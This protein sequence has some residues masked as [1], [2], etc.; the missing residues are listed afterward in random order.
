M[1][2]IKPF[3]I[4]K[5]SAGSGKTYQLASLYIELGLR[6]PPQFNR[7][8]GVTF[9]NKATAEMK[10]RIIKLLRSLNRGD[11]KVLLKNLSSE[12]GLS[13]NEIKI[14]S[15]ELLSR[16]LHSYS[17]FSITTIDS[18]F[19]KVIRSFAREL[20]VQGSFTVELDL[21][22]VTT[23]VIDNLLGDVHDPA[24]KEIKNWLIRYAD[25]KIRNG[26]SWDVRKELT[27]LAKETLK[28]SFKEHSEKLLSVSK[29]KDYFK[30]IVDELIKIKSI[31]ENDL[32][33][34][35]AK[36]IAIVESSGG[37]GIFKYGKSGPANA[38]Y[39]IQ[40]GKYELGKRALNSLEGIDHWLNK[41]NQSNPEVAKKV[42]EILIPTLSEIVDYIQSNSRK[43]N[44][45]NE[46]LKYF[47]TYGLI[48]SMLEYFRL[49]RE[50]EEVMFISDLPD[51]LK[52]IINDSDTPYIFEK[53]GSRYQNYL[54]DE[55][56]D[57]SHF[58]WNNIKP[59]VK[60]AT[61]SGYKSLV[62][63]D[64][65][66][67]IYRWRGGDFDLLENVIIDDI[68]SYNTEV[69][70]LDKNW[71]SSPVIVNFNNNLVKEISNNFQG[72]IELP[73][74][75]QPLVESALSV[76][77]NAEQIPVKSD[78]K[79][80]VQIKYFVSEEESWKNKSL[81]DT[82]KRIEDLQ[83]RNFRL[84][85]I[86]ILVRKNDHAELFA[87]FMLAYKESENARKDC[88]YDV[89][90]SEA[91]KLSS[92]LPIRIVINVLKWLESG[93]EEFYLFQWLN[94]YQLHRKKKG[95]VIQTI[96]ALKNWK[97]IVPKKFLESLSG[98]E[99][100][101]L[102]DLISQLILTLELNQKTDDFVYLQGFQDAL[103][104]FIN[105]NN[106]DISSFLQWW[107]QRGKNRPVQLSEETNA[108]RVFTIHKAKGLE[109]PVV[110]IPFLDW[111]LDYSNN[112]N[113]N[114]LWCSPVDQSP[115]NKMPVIPLKYGSKLK[116]TYWSDHY[117]SEKTLNFLDAV[118]MLY[119]SFT[120]P[121]QVLI[122]HGE[123]SKTS[124]NV[125]IGNYLHSLI[126]QNEFWNEDTSELKIN[127]FP[128]SV[129][130]KIDFRDYKLK[131]YQIS[132]WRKKVSLKN[133]DKSRAM[134]SAAESRKR[135][136]KWHDYLS[137]I[138]KVAD[139]EKIKDIDFRKKIEELVST[140]DVKQFFND[141]DEVYTER[142][143]LLPNG[144][145]KRLDR[146]I[147]KGEKWQ[148]IDFKTGEEKKQDQSQIKEYQSVLKEM[149]IQPVQCFLIYV[150]SAKVMEV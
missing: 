105:S 65:K 27:K 113:E 18:F 87:D 36:G 58:Q 144:S 52:Q 83:H 1:S 130:E 55:F 17:Q 125:T 149:D 134:D 33:K 80:S 126:K 139:L 11:E 70:L 103:L 46:V 90:S 16:I 131:N 54:I 71:R 94:D 31:F 62:V 77:K 69:S 129:S 22:N 140:E 38:F 93:K 75:H 88:K 8:L 119:V 49:Y 74:E 150:E 97:S 37:P 35:S 64:A 63:G 143:I 3:S 121:T 108:I 25:L 28:D 24:N 147:K 79:G 32:K 82:V 66:Q 127:D 84:S 107:D 133:V 91:L 44:S 99:K 47:F 111:E 145:V 20:G 115:F 85:D 43:Y 5:A 23:M 96:N 110:I 112:L 21:D 137:K 15:S 4:V 86:C 29:E 148:L 7:I 61:D 48:A 41:A 132:D 9:T 39:N 57:T 92:S 104:D 141:L 45:A 26:E 142:P 78:L 81:Y 122:A 6:N 123:Y 146:L 109:F 30:S 76:Y 10:E 2:Q 13:P 40:E 98:I 67:S 72:I 12:L 19:H 53:I 68:G 116:D 117:W 42:E 101:P 136:I 114:I 118:N 34:V 60:N 50:S 124:K 128:H 120:R 106:G 51:F 73:E 14:R 135:G 95:D 102:N 56:Q 59:L 138:E 89:V 100:L